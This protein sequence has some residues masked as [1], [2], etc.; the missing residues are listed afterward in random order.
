MDH[1]ER[2]ANHPTTW[3]TAE[4]LPEFLSI[5]RSLDEGTVRRDESHDL[6]SFFAH[7]LDAPPAY[8]R[9]ATTRYHPCR[10]LRCSVKHRVAAPHVGLHRM[11]HA[12]PVAERDRV[13]FA[14]TPAGAV[15]LSVR[16]ERGNHTVLHM[17]ERHRV[18]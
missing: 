15:V 10:A 18:M 7:Q 14:G 11:L 2:A 16:E 8:P 13:A 1:A 12:R 3:I 6:R 5:D 4:V 17:E 9:A